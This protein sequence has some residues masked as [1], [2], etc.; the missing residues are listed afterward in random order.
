VC[1]V[2]GT[3]YLAIRLAIDSIPPFLMG[4]ARWT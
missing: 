4:G 3:T 1:V 2:W